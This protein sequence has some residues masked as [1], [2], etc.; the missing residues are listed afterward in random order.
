MGFPAPGG[1]LGGPHW[2]LLQI[3]I[4]YESLF[5][6]ESINVGIPRWGSSS[7]YLSFI[8]YHKLTLKS[9]HL[10]SFNSSL[11]THLLWVTFYII[12]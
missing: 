10:K 6:A 11:Q 12:R 3:S 5:N 1:G 8:I 7:I 4:P 2:G 9:S